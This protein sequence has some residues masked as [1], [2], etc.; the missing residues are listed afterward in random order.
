MSVASALFLSFLYQIFDVSCDHDCSY[1]E[2]GGNN[3]H[4]YP[5]NKCWTENYDSK[6]PESS[7]SYI[8]IC[9]EDGT[10]VTWYYYNTSYDCSGNP[11]FAEVTLPTQQCYMNDC[12]IIIRY[13]TS[14]TNDRTIY[15]EYPYVSSTCFYNV[16]PGS[17]GYWRCNQDVVYEFFWLGSDTCDFINTTT[18][19]IFTTRASNN[20]S[21][22]ACNMSPS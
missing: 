1:I 9:N 22:I 4:Y 21:I 6:Y 18:Y 5:I 2:Y 20:V 14:K 15:Q 10:N 3:D 12:S 19:Q 8:W 7:S 17:S 13:Y 11:A 16:Y